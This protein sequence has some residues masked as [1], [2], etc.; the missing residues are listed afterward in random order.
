[1]H[2]VGF[3]STLDVPGLIV[4]SSSDG[5]GLLMEVPSLSVSTI[6]N[7]DDH[8]SVIDQVEVS[9]AIESSH[10]VEVSLNVKSELLVELTLSWLLLVLVNVNDSPLLMDLSSS[11]FN[12]NVS[13]LV[14]KST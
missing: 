8:V 5:Q 3:T 7:L 13:V 9:V 11:W 12:D 1:L 10:N 6:L 2:V 14:I 4:Q